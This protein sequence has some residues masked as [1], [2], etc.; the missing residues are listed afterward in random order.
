MENEFLDEWQK[1]LE[2]HL[3]DAA[4]NLMKHMGAYSAQIPIPDTTPSLV[5][6]IGEKDRIK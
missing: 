3:I 1:R 5:V 4:L 2:E 6:Y